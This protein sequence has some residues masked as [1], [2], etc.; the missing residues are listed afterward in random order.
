M[1]GTLR[2]NDV[3]YWTGPFNN[4]QS[5]WTYAK[6]L[7]QG[8]NM[9]SNFHRYTDVLMAILT[10]TIGRFKDWRLYMMCIYFWSHWKCIINAKFHWLWQIATSSASFTDNFGFFLDAISKAKNTFANLYHRISSKF[11]WQKG[12]LALTMAFNLLLSNLTYPNCHCQS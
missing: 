6:L 11:C 7:M 1:P 4:V 10:L 8:A 12:Y 2:L 5:L 3:K 9:G